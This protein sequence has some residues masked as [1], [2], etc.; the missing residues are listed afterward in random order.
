ML[1][2]ADGWPG[3]PTLLWV[4]LAMA[5]ARTLAMA[6]NRLADRFIDA[7]N[8]RTARRHLPA[9]LLTPAQVAGAAVAAGRLLLLS[10]FILKPLLPAPPPPPVLVLVLYPHTQR[11]PLPS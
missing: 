3:W 8:P 2:A 4:T 7:A 10:A 11:L 6:V 1:L 9:G 5:G